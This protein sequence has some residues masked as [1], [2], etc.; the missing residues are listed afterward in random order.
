MIQ[1]ESLKEKYAAREA[2]RPIVVGG[3]DP[4]RHPADD[5]M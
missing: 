3:G 5:P 1:Q 4:T 2:R